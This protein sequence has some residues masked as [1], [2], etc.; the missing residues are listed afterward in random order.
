MVHRNI[1]ETGVKRVSLIKEIAELIRKVLPKNA[2][3]Q[4]VSPKID[5]SIIGE[6]TLR[7]SEKNL[8]SSLPRTRLQGTMYM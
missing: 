4:Q 7:R 8:S 5:P 3:H 6:Q 1:E 2:S